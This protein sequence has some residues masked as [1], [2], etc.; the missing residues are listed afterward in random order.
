YFQLVYDPARWVSVLKIDP[1][2][3]ERVCVIG[4]TSKSYAMTGWRLGWAAAPVNIATAMSKLQSQVTSSASSIAQAACLEAVTNSHHFSEE[5]RGKF[6]LRRDFMIEG[7]SRIPGLK[8][9]QPEGAFYVFV[10]FSAV[11]NGKPVD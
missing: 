5:F 6:R 10:D 1:D 2:L 8:W 7:L 9:T 11:L 4:S 3:K